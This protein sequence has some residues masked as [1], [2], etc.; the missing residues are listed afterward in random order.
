MPCALRKTSEMDRR[1]QWGGGRRE[2]GGTIS[3]ARGGF[4]LVSRG[5]GVA[6]SRRSVRRTFPPP[7]GETRR[8][9]S[10]FPTEI[11]LSQAASSPKLPHSFDETETRAR[12]AP[13]RGLSCVLFRGVVTPGL[14][15]DESRALFVGRNTVKGASGYCETNTPNTNNHQQGEPR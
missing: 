11:P 12:D 7:G 13:R 9:V 10:D 1:R 15:I 8:P 5:E 4:G 6:C 3:G 2:G 14:G